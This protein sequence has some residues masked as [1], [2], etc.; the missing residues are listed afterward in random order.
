[1]I[2]TGVKILLLFS[3]VSLATAAAY[4]FIQQNEL[5]RQQAGLILQNR[6]M[7]KDVSQKFEEVYRT[8]DSLRD[9][10]ELERKTSDPAKEFIRFHGGDDHSRFSRVSLSWTLPASGS[11]T[12]P[13]RRAIVKSLLNKDLAAADADLGDLN[14]EKILH[15]VISAQTKANIETCEAELK[16][17]PGDWY[18]DKARTEIAATL[19]YERLD[20]IA[21][22]ADNPK[23]VTFY[24][25]RGGYSAGAAGG[26]LY[27]SYST[28]SKKDGSLLDSSAF[29]PG[30]KAALVRLIRAHAAP[31]ANPDA[32]NEGNIPQPFL[33]GDS[34]GFVFSS[35]EVGYH[36]HGSVT[37]KVPYKEVLPLIGK[38]WIDKFGL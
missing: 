13:V 37:L 23:W 32:I 12:E 26:Y 2:S 18:Y 28:F 19:H 9:A 25:S 14:L 34:V 38:Y 5:K 35:F 8:Q 17:H 16:D 31:D 33:L 24:A 3:V 10:F 22:A 20:S 4:L 27:E 21:P 7:Q 29:V 1:M 6:K 11:M 30:A 36:T 15:R